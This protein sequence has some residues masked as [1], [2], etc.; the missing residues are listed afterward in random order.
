M[1]Y[2][3]CLTIFVSSS[4]LFL[5]QPLFARLVVPVLGG[6]PSVWNTCMV[7]FQAMLLA[8]YAYAHGLAS[9]LSWRNQALLHAGVLLLPLLVLP[10]GLP[11][12]WTPPTSENPV[13]WLLALL[14][15]TVGLPFFAVATTSPLLQRWFSATGST[16][17][18]DPYFLYATSNVGSMLALLSYP[19]L[20]EPTL[21]LETQ[22]W[23]WAGGYALLVVLVYLCAASAFRSP[24]HPAIEP[25]DKNDVLITW[26]RRLRWLALS[27]VPSSLLLGLTAH[28]S[29]DIAAVPL[30][31]VLP[32]ALYLLTFIIAFSA[33]G[34]V[35]LPW[36]H[37]LTPLCIILVVLTLGRTSTQ[38]G[39]WWLMGLNIV[40]VFLAMWAC[41]ADL[42]A[43]RPPPRR[44]T[45]FYL[46][47][48]LGGVLG[49]CF[50]ALLAPVVF[51][52]IIEYP[53]ALMA[54]C[55]LRPR[56]GAENS[57]ARLYDV[58][59]PACLAIG[60]LALVWL[61]GAKKNPD[62][63]DS[64][65]LVL[66]LGLPAIVCFTFSDRPL[67][68]A[69]GVGALSLIS[70][71]YELF[72]E[73]VL[74][75]QRS[76]FG[77]HRVIDDRSS[78]MHRLVHGTTLHG[79]QSTNPSLQRTPMAYYHRS[80]P[81]GQVFGAF[82]NDPN[83]TKVGIIGLGSG[84]VA[85]LAGS[86]QH[87]TFFEI[88]PVV[89]HLAEDPKLFTYLTDLTR[90]RYRIVLGDGRL[91]LA[92]ARQKFGIIFVDA[93]T[94]DSIPVHL[95]T[96]EAVRVYLDKLD[97]GGLL[98]CN[99]SSRFFKLDDLMG[100]LADDAG[101]ACWVCA[102]LKITEEQKKEGKSPSRFAVLSRRPV[103][104]RSLAQDPRWRRIDGRAANI[105]WTDDFINLLRV[106]GR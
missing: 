31:W 42:A 39:E 46:L 80:G 74:F 89:A 25:E 19:F 32:L 88:D 34:T 97:E 47:L 68:L 106:L 11:T 72:H 38:G 26:P 21:T 2:V 36:L 5:L 55:L 67:R 8:G 29:T 14:T 86:S 81:L 59:L 10:F 30:F 44:L 23:F 49:G 6:S 27:A 95:L 37:R 73:P 56:R 33:K 41:H 75:A 102:D 60:I 18:R 103:D 87:L 90:D 52:S 40:T 53:L 13:P 24:G 98:V 70:L 99:I 69:L 83:K 50:N 84:G 4:L 94:S 28:V 45:E 61:F 66:I 43:D 77:V 58:I 16:A 76:F 105:V 20:L 12:G 96:R 65:N 17:G 1:Y 100:G 54:V 7:F 3:Y 79:W 63:S 101:L 92:D 71:A 35:A 51:N 91:T 78:E 22:R 93:F 15:V 82:G 48:S 62:S 64:V 104:F 57:K 85:P 9:R